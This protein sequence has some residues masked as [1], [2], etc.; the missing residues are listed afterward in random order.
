MRVRLWKLFIFFIVICAMAV[1]TA[2][3]QSAVNRDSIPARATGRLDNATRVLEAGKKVVLCFY[4]EDVLESEGVIPLAKELRREL[5][6]KA[7]VVTVP[8]T[9]ENDGTL[10]ENY[11]LTRVP[12]FVLMRPR[13]GIVGR[14]PG[15]AGKAA[16]VSAVTGEIEFDSSTK[17]IGNALRSGKPV[18]VEFYAEWCPACRKIK[19]LLARL[20]KRYNKKIGFVYVNVDSEPK[21]AW[22]YGIT[23]IPKLFLLDKNGTVVQTFGSNTTERD[24]RRAFAGLGIKE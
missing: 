4:T 3:G 14:M 2:Y 7:E 19:P 24:Y 13:V 9:F 5:K 18:L 10:M 1:L 20:E 21:I 23:F 17:R 11:S 16:L 6:G 12:V 22:N 15:T 8:F